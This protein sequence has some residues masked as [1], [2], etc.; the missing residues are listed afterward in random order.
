MFEALA[1]EVR[2]L[3]GWERV[4]SK[5]LIKRASDFAGNVHIFKR[6]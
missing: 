4:R 2:G 6:L 1:N 5:T 3:A